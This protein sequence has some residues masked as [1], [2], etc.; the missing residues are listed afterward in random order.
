MLVSP[1]VFSILLY[2]GLVVALGCIAVLAFRPA[3]ATGWRR[4]APTVGALVGLFVAG[5]CYIRKVEV[6][7]VEDGPSGPVAARKVALTSV[8]Y[9]FA[10]GEK[11]SSTSFSTGKPVWVVNHSSKVLR[12][13]SVAYGSNAYGMGT[14]E[15]VIPPGTAVQRGEI[16]HIGPDDRPPSSVEVDSRLP[17]DFRNWLTW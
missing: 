9:P 6:I 12:L 7:L 11:A 17:M 10:P 2:G 13:V 14:D 3:G 1:T 8:D 16:E 15:D 5:W 4:R